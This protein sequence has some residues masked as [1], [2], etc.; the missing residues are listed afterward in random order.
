MERSLRGPSTVVKAKVCLV[1]DSGVGKTSLVRRYVLDQ[2]DDRYISTLGAK[3]TKKEMRLD[4]PGA[5]GPVVVDLT[6]WDIMGQ[7]S[8]RDLLREA[9]FR[10][11]QAVLAVADITR[12]ETLEHLPDWIDAVLRTV[13][14]VPVVVAVN[15][16][17]LTAD[18]TYAPADVV[19]AAEVFRADVFVTSAKTGDNVEAA[20][21]RLASRVL[22]QAFR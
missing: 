17:D 21:G 7:P 14:S 15:K 18:A 8:F 20:F 16:A 2:F 12:R 1:G 6:I 9:Y 11:A 22:E 5:A 3:V 10:E 19:R 13:G 4:D